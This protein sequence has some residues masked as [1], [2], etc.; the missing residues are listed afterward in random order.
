MMKNIIYTLLLFL[1]F[2]SCKSAKINET[3]LRTSEIKNLGNYYTYV[4]E[5]RKVN[6]TTEAEP[7][8]LMFSNGVDSKRGLIHE[9]LYLLR[10]KTT[11]EVLYFT[12]KSHKYIKKGGVFNDTLNLYNRYNILNDIDNISIGKE[13]GN[14]FVFLDLNGREYSKKVIFSF[15]EKN[16]VLKIDSIS[17]NYA[18]KED[19]IKTPFIVLDDVFGTSMK[20]QKNLKPWVYS[21]EDA[22]FN[23]GGEY[24]NNEGAFE[25][26][27]EVFINYPYFFIRN[28]TDLGHYDCYYDG[29]YY[30]Y[31][32]RKI[33]KLNF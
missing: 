15:T 32:K 25:Y 24:F 8:A 21:W 2:T 11:N 22:N 27:T 12:T 4:F 26:I 28:T 16:G 1:F 23:R 13:N 7:T 19:R 29:F 30:H 17:N 18:I 3:I 5:L 20:F 31:R 6:K 33:R 14:E 10:H 9:M